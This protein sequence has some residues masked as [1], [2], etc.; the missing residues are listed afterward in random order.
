MRPLHLVLVIAL[1]SLMNGT[2]PA[3][4]DMPGMAA[5]VI[6]DGPDGGDDACGC[7]D[8][9]IVSCLVG[10]KRGTK[11]CFNGRWGPCELPEPPAPAAKVGT[12]RPKYFILMVIYAPPGT[13][14]GR[15]SSSVTY[16]S[17]STTGSTVSASRSFKKS[18]SVSVTASAGILGAKTQVGLS[19][20]YGTSTTDNQSIDIKKSGSTEITVP[21]P[22]VDGV[23]HDRDQIWL[24]LNPTLNVSLTPTS[25][26]WK[27]EDNP[28]AD[29]QF[30]F[31]GH[32]KDPSKMPPGL[33][34]RLQS[35]GITAADFPE[36]L[37]ADP[38]ANGSTAFID[39]K[40]Y[41][42]LNT[43]FPY[44]PPFA[45]GD[46]ATTFKF[47]AS[48]AINTSTSSSTQNET[49]VGV[50]ASGDVGFTSL[51]KTSVKAEGKWTWT[52]TETKASSS[53]TSESATVTVGG[54]AFGYTGPTDMAVYYDVIYKTFMFAP[55]VARP[56]I[57]G[58]VLDRTGTGVRS[59][60]V[61]VVSNGVA[62]RTFTNAK[63]EYR[64]FGDLSGPVRL[65]VDRT[66]RNL[67]QLPATR[68][69]DIQLP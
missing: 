14:G 11:Q 5:L 64:I 36:I 42:S 62:K 22:G 26:A 21:G 31:V 60:E 29:I 49:T 52:S 32:L 58:L 23:D 33:T 34:Q 65:Q 40:R 16:G 13:D 51:F 44:E 46:A 28:Q 66:I 4:N 45:Q 27:L 47:N 18:G 48:S 53:G 7:K 38:F 19:F 2:D 37:K 57:T 56:G 55:L 3:R 17:G 54:P 25:A 30:V 63:G 68:R 10:G 39:S 15:S 9:A 12:L 8:G 24:W 6:H 59:R 50:T 20:G 41:Q 69:V 1:L 35:Y 43:T 61:V 67:P